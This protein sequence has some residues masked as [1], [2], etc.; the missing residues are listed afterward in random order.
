MHFFTATQD[1]EKS[2]EENGE[3]GAKMAAM[4]CKLHFMNTEGMSEEELARVLDKLECKKCGGIFHKKFG[5][6]HHIAHDH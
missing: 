5:L 4:R 3:N 6:Q 2:T 1:R